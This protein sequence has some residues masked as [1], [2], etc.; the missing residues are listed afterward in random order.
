MPHFAS[1]G[2]DFLQQLNVYPVEPPSQMTQTAY[3]FAYDILIIRLQCRQ[4]CS[5]DL[6]Y[7]GAVNANPRKDKTIFGKVFQKSFPVMSIL[8]NRPYQ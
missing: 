4:N 6:F 7:V 1:A 5:M 2:M 3:A 8:K